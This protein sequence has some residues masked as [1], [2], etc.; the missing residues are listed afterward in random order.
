ME[1]TLQTQC[2]RAMNALPEPNDEQST[3]TLMSGVRTYFQHRDAR[4]AG[5]MHACTSVNVFPL[6]GVHVDRESG[7]IRM[8]NVVAA[9][10]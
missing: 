9:D 10:K 1:P 3:M 7:I 5:C 2:A 4:L 6:R 8:N